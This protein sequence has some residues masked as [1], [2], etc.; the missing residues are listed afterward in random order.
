MTL[1]EVERAVTE[2]Q[3]EQVQRE[4]VEKYKKERFA[5]WKD[6]ALVVCALGSLLLNVVVTFRF[7]K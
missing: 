6:T 5:K 4:A 7:F 2:L 3:K 1:E